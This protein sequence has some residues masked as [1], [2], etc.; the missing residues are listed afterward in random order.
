M[1][2]PFFFW[3]AW[4]IKYEV[5]PER[6]CPS[7]DLLEEFLHTLHGPDLTFSVEP[8]ECVWHESKPPKPPQIPRTRQIGLYDPTTGQLHSF[9]MT[10]LSDQRAEVTDT[11][12]DFIVQL[13]VTL[14]EVTLALEAHGS[15]SVDGQGYRAL[16]GF[17]LPHLPSS[18]KALWQEASAVPAA[19]SSLV[20]EQQVL[21]RLLAIAPRPSPCFNIMSANLW[22]YNHWESR[23]QV[24]AEEILRV[25]PDVIGFQEVRARKVSPHNQSRSQVFELAKLLGPGY[26]FEY[27]PSMEFAESSSEYVHEGLAIFSKFPILETASLALSRDSHDSNDFH[28][29]MV[30]RAKLDTPVGPVY[31]MTTHLSLSAKARKRTLPEIGQWTQHLQE[32]L[33]L[34]GDFNAQ[35][36]GDDNPLETEFGFEDAW[37]AKQQP[38]QQDPGW[39]FNSWDPKSRIDYILVRNLQVDSISIEGKQG[40]KWPSYLEP[41]GGVGDMKQTM[42][43]SDHMLLAARLSA[44]S[45]S[46]SSSSTSSSSSSSPS[47]KKTEL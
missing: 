17:T 25:S 32:P 34:L 31:F 19:Q 22:N 40:K 14:R 46:S 20:P 38:Q 45:S 21:S 44:S 39:T 30:L 36:Q 5:V 29:R 10:T 43:P 15:I 28:Q 1:R 23:K 41:V 11:R 9:E 24:L 12:T 16:T 18:A 7:F 47:S 13:G 37:K 35:F 8:K 3:L 2:W 6:G 4:A 26:Q 33:V 42:F 27:R